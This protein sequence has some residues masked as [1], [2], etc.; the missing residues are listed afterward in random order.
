MKI[1]L[2]GEMRRLLEPISIC[3]QGLRALAY[4]CTLSAD[5]LGE[6]ANK[7]IEELFELEEESSD[8]F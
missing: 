2:L 1:L 8:G 3:Q 4:C 6:L 7:L 5:F